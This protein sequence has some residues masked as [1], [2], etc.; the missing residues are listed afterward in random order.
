MVLLSQR[1]SLAVRDLGPSRSRR[2]FPRRKA[3]TQVILKSFP[4]RPCFRFV[5][6][7]PVFTQSRGVTLID[8]CYILV[9]LQICRE[10]IFQVKKG[11]YGISFTITQVLCITIYAS[12]TKRER[13]LSPPGRF[14][15]M[16]CSKV[17]DQRN[18][19]L[20]RPILKQP[21]NASGLCN[22]CRI[23]Q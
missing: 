9:G 22:D 7:K 21:I 5:K 4:V 11:I 14:E 1:N 12:L 13:S 6:A 17:S 15:I 16:I 23:L 19:K 3:F 2:V 8:I 20:M 18:F 10:V